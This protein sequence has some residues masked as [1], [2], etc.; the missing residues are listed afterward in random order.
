[1]VVFDG[2]R[3]LY[4]PLLHV[5]KIKLSD[6]TNGEVGQPAGF[7][8]S[9]KVESISYR[10]I[11]TNAKG[12]FTEIYVTGNQ[13]WHGYIINVLSDY[14]VFYSPV[15]KIM[16]IPLHHLKWLTLY[17]QNVLLIHSTKKPCLPI[18]ILLLYVVL[19]KNN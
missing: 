19:G 4:I 18:L 11:L 7:S 13:S 16:F 9:E 14:F 6:T 2:Q 12:L 15:Y 10:T 3:F 17:N 5:H 1:M 8:L